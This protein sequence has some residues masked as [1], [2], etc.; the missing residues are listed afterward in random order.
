MFYTY[1]YG[2]IAGKV[3]EVDSQIPRVV[4]RATQAGRIAGEVGEFDSQSPVVADRP[5]T[6]TS[7]VCLV[8]CEVGVF[9]SQGPF[10]VDRSTIANGSIANGVADE[11]RISNGEIAFAIDSPPLAAGLVVRVPRAGR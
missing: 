11:T 4:D 8:E 2:K 10:V 5:T 3:R 9:D 1:Q 7:A 6:M